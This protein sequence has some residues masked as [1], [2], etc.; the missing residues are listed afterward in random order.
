M[1]LIKCR[2]CKR[3]ISSEAKVC[4]LC[5]VN[6][7]YRKEWKDMP[8]WQK[9]FVIV[10]LAPI[11][12]MFILM[13]A[14]RESTLLKKVT[15]MSDT[16]F[17]EKYEGYSRL[18]SINSSNPEYTNQAIKYAKEY[19]K[20][21]PITQ[22]KENLAVYKSLA[23]LDLNEN[24]TDKI[25]FYTFMQD[26]SIDCAIAAQKLS[27]DSLNNKST[28]ESKMDSGGEWIDKNTYD[29]IDHYEGANSF[30]VVG[31]LIATYSCNVDY[32]TRRYSVTR[33][34]IATE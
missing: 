31:K 20:T 27:R 34:S 32:P 19:L 17:K 4:P 33:I 18:H 11:T 10:T 2:E 24:Y 13:F 6:K 30:G 8:R 14:N 12:L 7:P 28:Y 26:V 25:N 5:G 9:I 16:Q 1:A 21:L 3:D 23:D 22:P 15:A 29:Y